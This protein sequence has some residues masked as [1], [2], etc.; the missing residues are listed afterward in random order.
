[1]RHIPRYCE[2][3]QLPNPSVFSLKYSDNYMYFV[4]IYPLELLLFS[5]NRKEKSEQIKY[6]CVTLY[7]TIVNMCI[8]FRKKYYGLDE[9]RS[10]PCNKF[11]SLFLVLFCEILRVLSEVAFLYYFVKVL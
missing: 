7:H 4:M 9:K 11:N 3:S 8:I 1:M 10:L 5:K 6:L 2:K